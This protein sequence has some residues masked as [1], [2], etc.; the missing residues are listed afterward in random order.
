MS[1]SVF[2][3]FPTK[4]K[5]EEARQ[6]DRE[7]QKK[8]RIELEDAVVVVKTPDGKIKPN[9][10]MNTTS[11]RPDGALWETEVGML[12]LMPVVGTV[13]GAASGAL[14]GKMSDAG[15]DDEF[16]TDAA[17]QLQPGT[18]GLRP[19]SQDD[20]IRCWKICGRRRTVSR[21][22]FIDA[23]G[24]ATRSFGGACRHGGYLSTPPS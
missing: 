3:S 12:F 2:I 21:T 5:A 17:S 18:A 16:M 7:L 11:R 20:G 19:D 22:S 15:I 14:A 6:K 23:G 13:L 24:G 1:D 10:L 4:E 9:Q 8:N